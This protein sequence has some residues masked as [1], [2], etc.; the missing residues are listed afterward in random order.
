M[1]AAP[2]L[3]PMTP[4]I[5][6]ERETAEVRAQLVEHR[7]R[8]VTVIGPGGVGKTRLALEIAANARAVDGLDLAAFVALAS[9]G[10]P[11]LV[12]DAIAQGIG[13]RPTTDPDPVAPFWQLQAALRDT[14]RLLV[15]D[16][17]EHLT[18]A[19]TLVANLLTVCPRL[20]I[21]V[22]SRAPLHIQGEQLYLLHPLA[23]PTPEN[24]TAA[25]VGTAAA[26][27]LFVERAQASRPEFAL[28]DDNAQAVA[29]VCQ[30][31][32]GLPLA[33]ELAA[34]RISMFSPATLFA[35]LDRRLRLLSG[36][37][38]DLPERHRA[39]RDTV[40]WSYGLLSEHEQA[41]FRRLSVFAGG[42]DLDSAEA[43]S[44]GGDHLFDAVGALVDQSL[45]RRDA[46]ESG[47]ARFGMLETIRAYG[48]EKLEAAG[49][50]EATRERHADAMLALAEE[51]EPAINAG[52]A[53]GDQGRW[54][55]RL[56]ADHDNIRAALSWFLDEKSTRADDALRLAS[57]LW[58]FWESL[59]HLRE[60]QDW[61]GRALARTPDADLALRG[62]AFN[63]LGNI[64]LD[65]SDF[66][67]AEQCYQAALANR[68]KVGEPGPI[69]DT[70]NN[71]ALLA[72]D[73]GDPERSLAL[74]QETLEL[75][76]TLGAP[77]RVAVTL[78]NFAAALIQSDRGSEAKPLLEEA[79]AIRE[80]AGD[81]RGLAFST[82]HLGE[83][84][85]LNGEA[86]AARRHYE[87]SLAQLRAVENKRGTAFPLL[88]LGR[89][90]IATGDIRSAA[91]SLG[92]ALAIR[93][94]LGD[95]KGS[96]EVI[97]ALAEIAARVDRAATG[98][99]L[100]AA[101]ETLRDQLGSPPPPIFAAQRERTRTLL[102]TVLG[103]DAYAR[104]CAFG[105]AMALD[106]AVQT[107]VNIAH[108][109]SAKKRQPRQP[110]QRDQRPPRTRPRRPR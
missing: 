56:E 10:D 38:R 84:A 81:T 109:A 90:A 67:G 75:R 88:G 102:R 105:N 79:I 1:T 14:G 74:H 93:W 60:G 95:R 30:R 25:T 92:E 108:V 98:A 59:G 70:L 45:L 83:L 53:F 15:L 2:L 55:R 3:S 7:R 20:Q 66:L 43:V 52:G 41:I 73:R 94:D 99:R 26:A 42:F 6:R 23:V 47:V 77:E 49:E 28:T 68:R 97:E 11:A 5:G 106:T 21:L 96:A 89:L 78:S 12:V 76:R 50:V 16:N 86:E 100:L 8:L 110:R 13:L 18:D 87:A 71:L 9:I 44:Q 51:A 64:A 27:A 24:G 40:A 48:L 63:H 34:A 104:A 72:G 54:A 58:R 37:P 107:A 32:D 36:G 69:A 31:L 103:Q 57:A 62:K 29:A 101:T 80:A 65:H 17:F 46:D 4:L 39:M 85:R 61:L 22:T 91:R 82:Y 35:E 33:I 19:A